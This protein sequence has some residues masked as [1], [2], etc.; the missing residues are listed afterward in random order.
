MGPSP[1]S[2]LG[3]DA[4]FCIMNRNSIPMAQENKNLNQVYYEK[5]YQFPGRS[6]W[7]ERIWLEAMGDEYPAG[8]DQYGYL[9]NYDLRVMASLLPLTENSQLLDVGC[10]KGGPGLRLAE[11]LKC[12][13]TGI[14]I[15]AEAVEQARAFQSSFELKCPACFEVGSWDE[16][17]LEDNSVDAVIS[18]DSLW[19]APDKI[20]ALAEVKRVMKPGARF[21]FTNWDLLEQEPVP[22]LEMSGLSC[23]GRDDTPHW[24]S[25]Q[26]KVYA[27]IKKYKAELVEEMGEG[28]DM[29]LYEAE[30]SPAHLDRSARRMYL[31]ELVKEE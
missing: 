10:G 1:N 4:L 30:A 14:D 13:L 25:Y 27:G 29:L 11:Q 20:R 24:K 3:K 22:L 12:C 26:E 19:A 21:V 23:V 8:L 7:M 16:I 17:P 6:R 28:A 5:Y 15:V 18:I 9:T 31:F 2:L